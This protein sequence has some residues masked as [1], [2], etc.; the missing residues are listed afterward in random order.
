MFV[1]FIVLNYVLK[2]LFNYLDN[3]IGLVLCKV[4]IG[5]NVVWIGVVL[6]VLIF[7]VILVECFYIVMSLVSSNVKLIMWKVKVC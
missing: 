5:G 6:F 1:F 3:I 7:V 4:F 2:K